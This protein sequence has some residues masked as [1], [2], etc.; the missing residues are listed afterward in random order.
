MKIICEVISRYGNN[1]SGDKQYYFNIRCFVNKHKGLGSF[2][3][4]LP[5]DI[6]RG[7]QIIFVT[8]K[9]YIKYTDKN[10]FIQFDIFDTGNK[11]FN[12]TGENLTSLTPES[13]K[14]TTK[15][16]EKEFEIN[17]TE[18]LFK[19]FDYLIYFKENIGKLYN[20]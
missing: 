5:I 4:K 3:K 1:L 17:E 16:C 12:I 18:D 7:S 14:R 11:Y 15:I 9:N 6:R 10:S 2:I 19:I 20:I 8:Y 13:I